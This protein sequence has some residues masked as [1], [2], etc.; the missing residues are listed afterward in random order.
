M[1]N[2]TDGLP[3][4]AR[5]VYTGWFRERMADALFNWL[6]A[7]LVTRRSGVDDA[8]PSLLE[9][10]EFL[11]S[12]TVNIGPPRSV[13]SV[14]DDLHRKVRRW[15][16]DRPSVLVLRDV[17]LVG[18]NALPITPEGAFVVEAADGSTLRVTDAL[19]RA[20]GSG[21]VPVH[22]G[23]DDPYDCLV[24]F[25]GPW[26]EEFFHWFA[27]YLPRLR[28]LREY[29]AQTGVRPTL[30]IPSNPPT[31]LTDSLDRLGIDPARR[32]RWSGGR[33]S[34]DRLVVPSLPRHTHPTTPPEGYVHSP[35][36]L[37]WVANRLLDDVSASDRPD[38]GRRLY[39]SRAHQSTRH[40][41]NEADLLSVAEEFGFETVYPER[42]SLA[43]QLAAFAGADAV[44]GPHGAGLLNVIYA[45]DAVLV[46]LFG[47]RTNSCFFAIAEG[48]GIPYAMI[49]CRAIGSDLVVN[50]DDLRDLLTLALNV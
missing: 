17:D 42:W 5:R 35:R 20:I 30:L 23:T 29:E 43:E 44:L 50:P 9:R 34:L 21:R 38:I 26:S 19:V 27:D 32:V 37:R 13:G 11:T 22:R 48:M 40:V 41:R 39:V 3:G 12:E 8:P 15:E 49:E 33:W 47:E 16:F 28:V 2:S 14:P 10:R 4:V 1:S 7:P 31:W 18:A 25:A 46:E 45:D 6:D 36:G 24:S